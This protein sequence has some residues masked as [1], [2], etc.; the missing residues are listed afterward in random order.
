MTKILSILIA[1]IV[2]EAKALLFRPDQV[3]ISATFYVKLFCKKVFCKTFLYL[4]FDFVIFWQKNIGAKAAC[5]TS[6]NYT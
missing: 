5:T 2:V 6:L 1:T 3:S 4:Q